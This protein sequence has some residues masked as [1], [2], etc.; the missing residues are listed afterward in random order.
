MNLQALEVSLARVLDAP[1]SG[2]LRPDTPLDG[3]GVD[4]LARVLL[5][6][7]CRAAGIDVDPDTAWSARTVADLIDADLIDAD[8]IDAAGRSST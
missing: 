2:W 8:P 5:V 7:A 3:I 4:A 1:A 6:D